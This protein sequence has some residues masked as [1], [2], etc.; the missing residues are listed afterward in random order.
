[1]KDAQQGHLTIFKK[2]TLLKRPKNKI[3]N[4]KTQRQVKNK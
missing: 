4:F 1:M 2:R 3:K